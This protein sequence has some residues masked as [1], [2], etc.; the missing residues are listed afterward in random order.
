[1]WGSSPNEISRHFR[2]IGEAG[3]VIE[4]DQ[5]CRPIGTVGF[6]ASPIKYV[7]PTPSLNIK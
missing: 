5:R 7:E 1:M 3:I 4:G 2:I 6:V